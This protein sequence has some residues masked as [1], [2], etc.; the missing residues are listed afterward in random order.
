MG[1]SV[2]SAVLQSKRLQKWWKK[3][4]QHRTSKTRA[5]TEKQSGEWPQHRLPCK[6]PTPHGCPESGLRRGLPATHSVSSLPNFSGRGWRSGEIPSEAGEAVS[7]RETPD[8]APDPHPVPCP[9]LRWAALTAGQGGCCPRVPLGSGVQRGL[10]LLLC[11][12]SVEDSRRKPLSPWAPLATVD[13]K[14]DVGSSSF[15]SLYSFPEACPGGMAELAALHCSGP[16]HPPRAVK[17]R[18]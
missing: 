11:R 10:F 18:V 8:A 1:L 6:W 14:T 13:C 16:R 5:R 4:K 2:F 7:V 3:K 17:G 9:C 12:A 15:S